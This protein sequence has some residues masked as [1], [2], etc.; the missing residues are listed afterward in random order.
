MYHQRI[1]ISRLIANDQTFWLSNDDSFI[2]YISNV[3]A[4]ITINNNVWGL[5]L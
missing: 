5:A 3:W 1:P 2:Y 4:P